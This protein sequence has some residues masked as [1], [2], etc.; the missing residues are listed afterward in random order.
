MLQII[1]RITVGMLL[2]IHGFAHYHIATGWDART[3]AE[4]WLFAGVEP[5]SLLSLGNTLSTIALLA[6]VFTGFIVFF[7]MEWWRAV[8]VVAAIAS[9]IVIVLFWQPNMVLGIAVDVA[10][11]A[12]VLWMHWPTPEM[13]GA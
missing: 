13:I 5:N 10:I 1:L 12:A 9:L 6:F 2:I 11:L 8:A 3:T 7:G 4:S